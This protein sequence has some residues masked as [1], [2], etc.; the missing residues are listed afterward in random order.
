MAYGEAV[1]DP[2]VISGLHDRGD[3]FV[4]PIGG[5]TVD[6]LWFDNTFGMLHFGER[7]ATGKFQIQIEGGFAVA[8]AGESSTYEAADSVSLWP[9]LRLRGAVLMSAVAEKGGALI[10]EFDLALTV[11]VPPTPMWEAWRAAGPGFELI[12]LPGGGLSAPAFFNEHGHQVWI[13]I[14]DP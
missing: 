4:L 3:A 5:K 6:R 14:S 7:A 2:V 11:R 12:A 1:V 10:L 8:E 13:R 9:L